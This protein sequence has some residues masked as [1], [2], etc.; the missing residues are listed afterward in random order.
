VRRRGGRGKGLGRG[1]S[2]K[3]PKEEESHFSFSVAYPDKMERMCTKVHLIR[4]LV[5]LEG[6][7]GEEDGVRGRQRDLLEKTHHKRSHTR[8]SGT[9]TE[10][11]VA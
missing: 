9:I 1:Q 4:V 10:P 8:M 7:L 3:V 11:I 2:R 6:S 5:I